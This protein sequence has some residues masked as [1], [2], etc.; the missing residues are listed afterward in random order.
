ML[1][2]SGPRDEEPIQNGFVAAAFQLALVG[3]KVKTNPARLVAHEGQKMSEF[4]SIRYLLPEE[5]ARLRT[6]IEQ[7]CKD[8]LPALDVALHTGMRKSE[9]FS[10]EWAEVAFDRHRIY[11][12]ETKNGSSREIPMSKTCFDA[13]E[14]L[15]SVSKNEQVFQASRYKQALKDPR[16][17]FDECAHRK[18]RLQISAGMT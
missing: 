6:A 2:L 3:G 14:K 9:Q 4:G 16:K 5:E 10:L 13:L 17:W 11:L 12:N 7:R 1:I 8:Q 18:P 15:H